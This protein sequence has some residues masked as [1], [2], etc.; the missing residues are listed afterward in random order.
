[1]TMPTQHRRFLC[2]LSS[3][4]LGLAAIASRAAESTNSPLL[5][6][7]RIFDSDEFNGESFGPF[8]WRKHGGGYTT[9]EKPGGTGPGKDL[10]LNDPATGAKEI[11]VPAHLLIPPGE[12]S[13][14]AIDDYVLSEDESKLLVYTNSK[15][16]WRRRTRGDYWVLDIAARGLKKL[17]GAV[18]PSSL[19]FATFSPDGR[20]VCYV[21]ENNLYVQNLRD[22]K[23]VQLTRDGSETLINGTFDWVY[24]EELDLRNGFRWSPDSRSIAYWQLDTAGVKRFQLIND[25][26]DLYSRVINIPYP[27]VGEQNSAGRV[28]VINVEGGGTTW[29]QAPGDP[30]D[31]Y[32]ARM[33]WAENSDEIVLQQFNRLQN[34]NR[35]MLADAKSGGVRTVLTE[36]D[37]AWV[38][39]DNKPWWTESGHQFVWLS[40]R[41]GWRH[42]YL[43]SRSGKKP[44]LITKGK[45]DVVSVQTID[46]ANGWLYFIAS[47]DNPT[48]RYLYRARLTGGKAKRVTPADQ[49][50]THSYDISPD[51]KWA[52]HTFS[53]FDRPPVVDFITLPDHKSV[54]VL[55]ENG[56]LVKK[57][58][59]LKKPETEFFRVDIEENVSL[60]A[61]CIK[62]PDFDPAKKYPVLFHVYGEPAG[63]TVL[64]RWGG[65]SYF[66]HTMLAQQGYLVMSVDN[67]GTPSPRGR[68][69]RKSIY[70]QVGILASAE[71][72]AA[73]RSL[74]K[75]RG[76]ID[77]S[78]VAIWGWSGGGS[79][80]LNAIFRYPEIYQ[81]AMSVAPVP[82]QRYYD[83]IYQERYMGLPGDNAEGYRKGS[84]IT[85]AHQLKGNLLL[86]HGTGDDNCHYQGT[87]ALINE[88][89]AHNKKFSMMA[90]PNR[91][92]GISEGK[93]TTRH[94]HQVLTQ[95]L[96]EHTPRNPDAK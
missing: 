75:Q 29:V 8:Q 39:N 83:S 74:V 72:A 35:V 19:M 16:V 96:N 37:A 40:E 49:K 18:Q 81:T 21:R 54:R 93:N 78:R 58:E 95:F 20:R 85:Y 15:R 38:E 90:Y 68:E 92:H 11:L 66:W 52:V 60:D 57:L 63:Q 7:D 77:A 26:E 28:G 42:A 14:L 55:A 65:R 9:L 1:M 5:N 86:V 2:L 87:E 94:L 12:S 53:A 76:Y 79:M 44:S 25:T 13:P 91:S 88:L 84:A 59:G 34:T 46:E 82:N 10:V 71:Q 22:L 69:W 67:R 24:E 6:L 48:Q 33:D 80:S 23:I 3:L 62:P 64:D 61:W 47:P 41:D 32:L 36:S 70:R 89:I 56:K 51:A 43:V 31:H 17:G 30:R 4:F 50:G 73:V 27:K 45:L